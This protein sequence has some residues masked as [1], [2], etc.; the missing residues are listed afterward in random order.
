[1]NQ[2]T[3]PCCKIASSSSSRNALVLAICLIALLHSSPTYA[4][5]RSTLPNDVASWSDL[6][7]RQIGQNLF[8]AMKSVLDSSSL[9][10]HQFTG[11]QVIFSVDGTRRPGEAIDSIE[12]RSGFT[13]TMSACPN[14][15]SPRANVASVFF[16]M[17]VFQQSVP[18]LLH[19]LFAASKRRG[20]EPMTARHS[21]RQGERGL[22]LEWKQ[23]AASETI[24]VL[25]DR[26]GSTNLRWSF[27]DESNC[28]R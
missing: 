11:N 10:L 6:L 12:Q 8:D 1:M 9:I 18:D 28:N 5:Q 15:N 25:A 17:D 24:G 14:S 13:I 21:S 26:N 4:Q 27:L 7:R 20:S 23:G 16:E 2:Q 19:N 22:V 3:I